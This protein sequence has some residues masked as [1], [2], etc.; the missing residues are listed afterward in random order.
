M[1]FILG[2]VGLFLIF[3]GVNSDKG[4][5]LVALAVLVYLIDRKTGD[6]E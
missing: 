2:V 4:I 1:D 5:V 6:D 3:S